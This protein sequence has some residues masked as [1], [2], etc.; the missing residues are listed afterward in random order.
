MRDLYLRG[1]ERVDVDVL[2][3]CKVSHQL[4]SLHLRPVPVP[5]RL[6][7]KMPDHAA[8]VQAGTADAAKATVAA[9]CAPANVTGFQ[10]AYVDAVIAC[11]VVGDVK[12]GGGAVASQ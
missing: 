4:D 8:R 12:A 1:A 6:E 5:R 2:V 10:D 3:I 7:A 11:K 9:R